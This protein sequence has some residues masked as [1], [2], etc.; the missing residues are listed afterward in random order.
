M[1]TEKILD[2]VCTSHTAFAKD[3]KLQV[4][5]LNMYEN[6]DALANQK[7]E[8]P[9]ER[10]AFET[11]NACVKVLVE[12]RVDYLPWADSFARYVV[13]RNENLTTVETN[14]PVFFFMGVQKENTALQ[15]TLNEGLK[16]LKEN[17]KLDA[18]IETWLRNTPTDE[19]L[20]AQVI[21]EM[22]GEQVVK[23]AITADCPP[24]DYVDV[25]GKPCGFNVALLSALSEVT[26]IRF[27]L[28]EIASSARLVALQSGKVDALF[29]TIS[30]GAYMPKQENRLLFTDSYYSENIMCLCTKDNQ[31]I[32]QKHVDDITR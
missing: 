15:A 5:G 31:P 32:I 6:E 3:Q 28:V 2:S 22:K 4:G 1:K 23:I 13:A 25:T 26:N 7:P 19:E 29:Y 17:G 12:G 21:P 9:I 30:K 24:L 10:I 20:T 14:I 11:A 18:L 27:E 8:D 16:K